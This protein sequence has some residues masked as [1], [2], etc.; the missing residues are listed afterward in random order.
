M[1]NSYKTGI[2]HSGHQVEGGAVQDCSNSSSLAMELLQSNTKPSKWS[3]SGQLQR[4]L[5]TCMI[6]WAPNPL[7]QI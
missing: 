6:L 7:H 2:K 3:H 1:H 4:G 5:E